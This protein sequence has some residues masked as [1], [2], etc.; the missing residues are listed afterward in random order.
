MELIDLER[1][2]WSRN[3]DEEEYEDEV[4]T[5]DY[6]TPIFVRSKHFAQ[7]VPEKYNAKVLLVGIHAA[8]TCFLHCSF[9]KRT[10]IGSLILPEISMKNNTLEPSVNDN[11][12]TIYK[13][14][15]D[16]S[17]VLVLCQYEVSAERSYAWANCLFQNLNPERVYALDRIL[18]SHYDS[19]NPH[20]SRT[21][22]MLRS[23]E[24]TTYKN[25][26]H[27]QFCPY[28]EAPNLVDK[29]AAALM[30]HCE[31]RNVPA[32]LILSLEDSRF[33]ELE[34]LKAFEPIFLTLGLL[35]LQSPEQQ[36]NLYKK[37]VQSL[38][39]R[40]PNLLYM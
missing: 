1:T 14:D 8:A 22:P 26:S 12:C 20:V 33:L 31:L 32:T 17:V 16:P 21:P 28:L 35:Q 24:T 5:T 3:W 25:Q 39:S 18:D 15:N 38:S 23:L 9:P 36:H 29:A 11:T 4:Q 2:S 34:T 27:K 6:T 40:K 19:T 37:T 10:I 30:T 13:L 7:S